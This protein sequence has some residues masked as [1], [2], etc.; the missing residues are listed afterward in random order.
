MIERDAEWWMKRIASEPNYPITAGVPTARDAL[1][2]CQQ[3][4]AIG[5]EETDDTGPLADLFAAIHRTAASALASADPPTN[6]AD[7]DA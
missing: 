7:R 4:A 3:F 1:W 2:M 5:I 6:E